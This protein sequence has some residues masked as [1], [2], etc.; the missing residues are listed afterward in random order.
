MPARTQLVDVFHHDD[1][2][3]YRDAEERQK[4]NAGGDAEVGG[5]HDEGHHASDRRHG[6]RHQNETGPFHGSE[7]GVQDHEND[8]EGE[9][10]HDRQP[11]L[12]ALLA[13]IFARPV[14]AISGRQLHLLVDPA[15]RL[16]N[17]AAQIASA[18]AIF[19]RDIPLVA[20]AIHLRRAVQYLDSTELGERDALPSGREEAD[21][22]DR[23]FGVTEARQIPHNEVVALFAL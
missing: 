10:N 12:C 1:T 14:D 23:F 3:L 17:R 2:G 22:L 19:D 15:D 4:S 20:L 13:R 8:Q 11:S 9:R 5:A 18:D 7:H 16:L 6:D 21:L